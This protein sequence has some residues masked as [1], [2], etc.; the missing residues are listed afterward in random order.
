MAR[1][2]FV[3]P[4]W[5]W[6]AYCSFV[7]ITTPFVYL[8]WQGDPAMVCTLAFLTGIAGGLVWLYGRLRRKNL[9]VRWA[10]ATTYFAAITGSVAASAFTPTGVLP[11]PW[12]IALAAALGLNS[13]GWACW[14]VRQLR[15]GWQTACW[16]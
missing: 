9:A 11:V 4:L 7:S 15:R 3:P 2:S 8:W 10:G 6:V 13:L 16:G 1:P 12:A 5:L 14:C